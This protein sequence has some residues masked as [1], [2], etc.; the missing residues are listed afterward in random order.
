MGAYGCPGG[1][2]TLLALSVSF[3]R[4][5]RC[6]VDGAVKAI[7]TAPL[8]A[9]STQHRWPRSELTGTA[10]GVT[11]SWAATDKQ[12]SLSS[13]NIINLLT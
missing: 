7:L 10:S 3:E 13:T 12:L 8:A 1:V 2:V 5:H 11:A 6:R 4:G 9:P